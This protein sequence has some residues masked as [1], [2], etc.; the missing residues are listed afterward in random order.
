MAAAAWLF[1]VW[2]GEARYQSHKPGRLADG[3]LESGWSDA[4]SF[5]G[6]GDVAIF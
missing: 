5:G 6:G 3:S 1:A 4:E 2:F